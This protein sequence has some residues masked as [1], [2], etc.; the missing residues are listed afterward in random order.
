MRQQTR[1]NF[2]SEIFSLLCMM[3]SL[4]NR[5]IFRHLELL[6]AEVTLMVQLSIVSLQV[7]FNTSWLKLFLAQMTGHFFGKLFPPVILS[8]VIENK[9]FREEPRDLRA[10]FTFVLQILNT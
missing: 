1:I 9:I 2:L 7:S 3:F 6:V 5:Q 10:E 8:H 4:V